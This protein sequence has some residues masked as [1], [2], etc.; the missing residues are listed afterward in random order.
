MDEPRRMDKDIEG[1]KIMVN[2]RGANLSLW[3]LLGDSQL[4]VVTCRPLSSMVLC[5]MDSG[6]KASED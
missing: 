2:I 4:S 3:R 5:G 1:K 6:A